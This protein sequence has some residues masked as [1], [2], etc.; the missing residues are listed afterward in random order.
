MQVGL[1]TWYSSC[2]GKQCSMRRSISC[3]GQTQPMYTLADPLEVFNQHVTA[4]GPTVPPTSGPDPETEKRSA[5]DKSVLDA[6]LEN[7]ARTR[8]RLGVSDQQKM[9]EFLESVRSVEQRVT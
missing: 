5:L 9:D 2:D 8:S 1:S 7:A 3:A 6:V 4:A